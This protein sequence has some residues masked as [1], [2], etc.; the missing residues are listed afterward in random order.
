M[1]RLIAI[2]AI[3]TAA[4]TVAFTPAA[5][6]Q[7]DIFGLSAPKTPVALAKN[8]NLPVSPELLT[9]LARA[10]HRGLAFRAK[11]DA[12]ELKAIPGSRLTNDGKIGL[13]YVGADFCP[14]CA[15]ERWGVMLTLLRFGKLS[16]LRYM[17]STADDVYPNTATVTFQHASYES[18]YLDFQVV[19]TADRAEH[20]LMTPNQSQMKIL[21]TF[22]A[23]PYTRFTESIPFVYLDGKY[24]LGQLLVMPEPLKDKNW[25]Q[26]ATALANP[27]S[28]LFR[29][30]MPRVNLPT[31]AICHLDGGKPLDVCTA[32][33]VAAAKGILPG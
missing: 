16:G 32:P 15:G 12:T 17:L 7:L 14:Y 13:L 11:S 18:P 19:E 25:Q 10:S 27:K 31:A 23:P 5:R 29:R 21:S 3:L 28:A 33:G 26:V 6:A 22:D 2:A 1:P 30:V 24:E 8:L 20:P 9:T 4:A